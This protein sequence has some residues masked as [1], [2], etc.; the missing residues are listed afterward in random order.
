[1]HTN[2]ELVRHKWPNVSACMQAR[3]VSV[4]LR[5]HLVVRACRREISAAVLH[6]F[7]S[8]FV[9]VCVSVFLESFMLGMCTNELESSSFHST[10]IK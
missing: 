7:R 3:H 4:S 5:S 2:R 8:L 6:V 1:M 10:A 9:Y